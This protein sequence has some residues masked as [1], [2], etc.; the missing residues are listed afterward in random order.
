MGFFFKYMFIN[1]LTIW[2]ELSLVAFITVC[3]YRLLIA[4]L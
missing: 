1:V 4:V 2:W 3:P